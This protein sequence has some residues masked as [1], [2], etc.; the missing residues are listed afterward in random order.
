MVS[1]TFRIPQILCDAADL[2]DSRTAGWTSAQQ[3]RMMQGKYQELM[4]C[5]HR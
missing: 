5:R 2:K 1:N 3:L 4:A